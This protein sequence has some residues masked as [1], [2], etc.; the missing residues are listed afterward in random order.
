[1]NI[2]DYVALRFSPLALS[3]E[4]AENKRTFLLS[5]LFLLPLVVHLIFFYFEVFSRKSKTKQKHRMHLSAPKRHGLHV[6]DRRRKSLP[7]H[8]FR[9]SRWRFF[10]FSTFCHVN[11]IYKFAFLN[12]FSTDDFNHFDRQ[13]LLCFSGTFN[14]T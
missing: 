13:R 9:I 11:P 2:C 7:S 8:R 5:Y 3:L 10:L 1:M 6:D 12:P 14:I 4:L